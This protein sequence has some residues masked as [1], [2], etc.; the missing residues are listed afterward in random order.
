MSAA[1]DK[2]IFYKDNKKE[3]RYR[4]TSAN[5]KKV[6]YASESFKRLTDARKNWL[7]GFVQPKEVI[8][9]KN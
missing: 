8:Y 6:H 2:V 3:W 9:L 1:N 7:R 4:R 5:G